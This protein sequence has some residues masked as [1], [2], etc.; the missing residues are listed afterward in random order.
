MGEYFQIQDDYLDCFGDAEVIGKVGTDIQDNKCSWLVVQALERCSRTQKKQL[1]ANYG[2]WDDA[3]VV[4]V[5]KLYN[6]LDL[7]GVFAEYEEAS[8]KEIQAELDKVNL[9]PRD[10]FELL[11]NKIYKRS[12]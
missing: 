6:D 10:V 9:M 5:K 11:L 12:K 3:K 4:K 8:Y 1:E 7:Q 2:V